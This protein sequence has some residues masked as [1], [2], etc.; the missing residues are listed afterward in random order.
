MQITHSDVTGQI[1][2][3]FKDNITSGEWK[4][5]EKIPS[6]NQLTQILGVSRASVRTAIQQL[7]GTGVLES[8]HGKGTF[9]LD[10]QVEDAADIANKITAEDCKDIEKVLEFRRI[11]ES[12]ACYMAAERADEKLTAE[13]ERWLVKMEESIN[14]RESFVTADVNF[15]KV[16]SAACGNLLLEKS[17]YK[18]FEE[19]RKNH[20]Q[21][22]EIFGYR[23][24][25]YYHTKILEAMKNGDAIKA[26][27]YMYEHLQNAINRLQD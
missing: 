25:I 7:V 27:E 21:M 20:R 8:I 17:L 9:L 11:V 2:Q 10:D 26:R 22:N 18:V 12:E 13:L 6:E 23:D 15:H 3:Y 14:K 1:V 5:G 16:I 4:I 24:G 19:T